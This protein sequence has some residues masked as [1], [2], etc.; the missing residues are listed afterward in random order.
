MS[1]P[2]YDPK[3]LEA[4]REVLIDTGCA[5]DHATEIAERFLSAYHEAISV[6][7]RPRNQTEDAVSGALKRHFPNATELDLASL[8]G[9]IMDALYPGP[10]EEV[11][12]GG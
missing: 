12:S 11:K 10:T 4:A 3:A 1:T 7:N 6:K 8:L 2:Q 9:G 5:P